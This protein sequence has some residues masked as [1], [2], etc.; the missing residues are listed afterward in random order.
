MKLNIPQLTLAKLGQLSRNQSG[1]QE[2]PGSILTGGNFSAEI[3]LLFTTHVSNTKLTTLPTL[4]IYGKTW[5]VS[6]WHV[7]LVL[8]VDSLQIGGNN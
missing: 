8:R 7:L 1:L 2:V 5:T 3:I 4:C 6:Y